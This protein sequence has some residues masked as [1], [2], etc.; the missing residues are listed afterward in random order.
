MSTV[1]S[2]SACILYGSW[3]PFMIAS[4]VMLENSFFGFSEIA[5]SNSLQQGCYMGTSLYR[6]RYQYARYSELNLKVSRNKDIRG[7]TGI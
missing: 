6:S 4:K 7:D 3:L 5:I 1:S 2:S